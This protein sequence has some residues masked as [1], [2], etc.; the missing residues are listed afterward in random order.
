MGAH[1]SEDCIP[2]PVGWGHSQAQRR[3]LKH[4]SVE[5]KKTKQQHRRVLLVPPG[6][7]NSG[8][9]CWAP[10]QWGE[11]P[12]AAGAAPCAV[13]GAE[14]SAAVCGP[15]A[16]H[17]GVGGL[18]WVLREQKLTLRKQKT[19]SR[20]KREMWAEAASPRPATRGV[21]PPSAAARSTPGCAGPRV[22]GRSVVYAVTAS[23]PPTGPRG[24]SSPA[25]PSR[26][27]TPPSSHKPTPTEPPT[28]DIPTPRG[29]GA[30]Q[31]IPA[32]RR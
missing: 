13:S 16:P 31:H 32:A 24:G 6:S 22:L 26:S 25:L 18:R 8:V 5:V 30:A 12:G 15:S 3:A 17:R 21:S 4:Q 10:K 9:C 14:L 20:G 19:G 2:A 28:A 7:G 11:T 27:L 1:Q 29:F 23:E